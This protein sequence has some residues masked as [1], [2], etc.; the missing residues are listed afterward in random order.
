MVLSYYRMQTARNYLISISGSKASPQGPPLRFAV[1]L[2]MKCKINEDCKEGLRTGA[3]TED[4][5]SNQ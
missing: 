5:N 2:E 3:R 1:C 4:L